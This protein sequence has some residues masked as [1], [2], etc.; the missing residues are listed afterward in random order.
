[1]V[2]QAVKGVILDDSV[3]FI[4]SGGNNP[5]HSLR[6]A[7]DALLRYLRYSMFRTGI[8][9]RL[10]SSDCK[11]IIK[12][13]AESHSIDF[14]SLSAFLTKDDINEIMLSWG[15]VCN[16]ILYVISSERKDDINHLIDQGW[17]VVVLNVQD[18]SACE[19]LGMICISKLEELPL[20]ICRLNRKAVDSS[21]LVVGY[22]MK[23]SRELDFSK[24]GAFPLYPTDNGLIFMPLT[25][26][27]PL[28]SQLP[29]VDMI[30]HKATDEILYVELSNSSD[31]SNKITYSSRMQELQR[32]I[33]VHPDLCVI[34]PLD[35]IKP[36]LDRVEIQQ[37]LLGLEALK[38][39]GCIIRG[40]YFLKVGN[41]NE[42][43]LV[44]KL[45][46]AKL[47]L[48]CIVKPQVACGVSDAHKMAIIFYVEDIKNLDVP[49][50]AI[51][52]EYV[53]HS[54][55]LYKFYVLGEKIF[56]AVK[57][58]TPN[59]SAL[60]NLNQGVGPLV[61]DSLKSLPIANESQQHLEGKSSD[62][63]NKDMNIELVQNSANW[64]RRVLD[65]SIFGFDVVVE[66]KSGDHVIVDVNY[67]PSFKEVPD[68]IAIPAFWEAI[69]NKYENFKKLST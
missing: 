45:S 49:L 38:S 10:D 15:D 34:D 48:P 28:S 46:E 68:N 11:D 33:E 44:Q 56:Y 6:P 60:I 65:L 62:N 21:I 19:N 42:A 40:P 27:L 36:V 2:G 51:I 31:L 54:S 25:F 58:S 53:D 23:P 63:K 64:L 55:T 52:Q 66:D 29:E 61:F 8:S 39:E 30:L 26:D 41:F 18:D 43:N 22:T 3:L 35:N 1:M 57:K 17:L 7:A 47:S 32:Y 13:K 37:I 9:S 16:S 69:K 5:K 20:S 4:S 24:R 50:P 14:F 12:E 67:L 59:I